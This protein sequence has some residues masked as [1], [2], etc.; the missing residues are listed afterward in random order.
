MILFYSVIFE[1]Y[2]NNQAN[3]TIHLFLIYNQF[4]LNN[5]SY[6]N[7]CFSLTST[8]FVSGMVDVIIGLLCLSSI[9]WCL[10]H[11]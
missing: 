4:I 3:I 2:N 10:Y 6:I 11:S 8:T 9:L 7:Y 1:R 5:C